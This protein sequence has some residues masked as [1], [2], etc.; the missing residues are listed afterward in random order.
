MLRDSSVTF[1]ASLK[2]PISEEK[3][4]IPSANIQILPQNGFP[5]WLGPK[6][7]K[8]FSKGMWVLILK[9]LKYF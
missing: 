3:K 2:N 7:I 9:G 4:K 6:E 8:R 1:N 5:E